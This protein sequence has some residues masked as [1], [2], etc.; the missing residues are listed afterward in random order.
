M[1]VYA[2]TE[3]AGKLRELRAI[4][5]ALG[6]EVAAFEG[7]A[8]PVEGD[9]SYAENAALKARALA[10][11]LRAAGIG[12]AA[13]GDDSGLEVAALGGRPG[14][15]SARYAGSVATWSERRRTLLAELASS[16]SKDRRARFV[17]AM[18]LVTAEGREIE[19]QASLQGLVADRERGEGGFSYDAIFDYPPL[20]KTFGELS[21]E[22]KNAIS[23]RGLAAQALVAK[24][25]A[26]APVRGM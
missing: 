1:L 11:Q 14:V 20:A 13:V 17:C 21:E 4:L 8:A 5:G 2:A 10:T 18:H 23:H 9:A 6:W 16:G 15:L 22:E 24:A 7:Y 19:A 3:N 25:V 12:A 26:A